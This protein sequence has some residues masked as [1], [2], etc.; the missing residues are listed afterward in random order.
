MARILLLMFLLIVVAGCG[1]KKYV[2]YQGRS[3]DIQALQAK[4]GKVDVGV[5]KIAIEPKFRQVSHR[6][7][8]LDLL[9]V[10]T[11]NEISS[12]KD[13]PPKENLRAK[14][15]ER[16]LQL[17]LIAVEHY[18]KVNSSSEKQDRVCKDFSGVWELKA[19]PRRPH[20]VIV[21]NDCEFTGV[22]DVPGVHHAFSGTIVGRRSDARMV[23]TADCGVQV[24][25]LTLERTVDTLQQSVTS[26]QLTSGS[27][28][29]VG[30][31]MN[32]LIYDKSGGDQG[33]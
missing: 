14:Y 25:N 8:E 27:C 17:Q 7:E 12:M 18:E 5:G 9:Q 20:L 10:N 23:R 22:M 31:T 16:L 24:W 4:T 2:Q 15:V 19:D 13:G 28:V 33:K 29:Q 26:S 3:I 6:V 11:C 30:A 21:Q 1:C 32:P